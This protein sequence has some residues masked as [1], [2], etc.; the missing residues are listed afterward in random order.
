MRT[1]L[2]AG[3]IAVA[4]LLLSGVG[5]GQTFPWQS[6]QK[7]AGKGASIVQFAGPEQISVQ[8]GQPQEVEL[9]F[10]VAPGYHI[11]SHTPHGKTLIPTQLMITEGS[12]LDVTRVDFPQGT[13]TSFAFAPDE[14]LNVYMGDVVLRAHLKAKP[15]S[16]LLQGALRY[17]ACDQNACMPPKTTAVAV[18]VLAK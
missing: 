12:G 4:A 14:K 16:Q 8:A 18:S 13:D 10:Q 15:G 1:L 9:R 17:Q 3:G 5:L 11:N 7:A 2:R 6:A